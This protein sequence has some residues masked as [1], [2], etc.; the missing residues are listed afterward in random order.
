MLNHKPFT[1]ISPE[2]SF[3]MVTPL[4]KTDKPGTYKVQAELACVGDSVFQLKVG[5]KEVTCKTQATGS[6]Q[7][8]KQ[9]SLGSIEIEKPGTYTLQ[10]TPDKKWKPINLRSIELK[11]E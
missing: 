10:I 3:L 11:L 7:D 1:N 9:V 6:F 5:D 2:Y 4:F 8:F